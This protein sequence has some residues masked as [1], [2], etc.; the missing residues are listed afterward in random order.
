MTEKEAEG[1]CICLA[2]NRPYGNEAWQHE[3]AKQLG[4][5]HTLRNEGRL[6]AKPQIN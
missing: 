4:L 3:Q 6:K 5:S 2:R 1:L